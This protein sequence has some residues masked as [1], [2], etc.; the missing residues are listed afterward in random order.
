[1]TSNLSQ[2]EIMNMSVDL[3]S[4][5]PLSG[6]NDTS[7]IAKRLKR[8]FP[9]VR[10]QELRKHPWNFA[11]TRTQ[12]AASTFTP[13]FG[14]QYG[15]PLPAG[16]L[17]VYDLQRD[18]YFEG[19]SIPYAIE[20]DGTDHLAILTD[21]AAPLYLKYIKRIT[22]TGLFDP[23]FCAAVAAKLAMVVSHSTTGKASMFDRCAAAYEAALK[24]ARAT[25]ALEGTP[26]RPESN[27]WDDA[28]FEHWG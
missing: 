14:W 11:T 7:A 23:L 20:N 10:D 27:E 26:E 5:A 4:D 6:M 22:A 25:D 8:N 21:Q 24:D 12:L 16:C 13:E 19:R 15:Y 17:R 28:R 18:P 3:L 1:M 2:V 9:I